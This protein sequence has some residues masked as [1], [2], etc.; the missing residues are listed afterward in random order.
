MNRAAVIIGLQVV[1][2]CPVWR[3]YVERLTTGGGEEAWG[4]LA[5]ATAAGCYWKGAKPVDAEKSRLFPLWLPAA[6]VLVYAAAYPV[7]PPLMRAMV[8]FAAL[9]CTLNLWRFGRAFHPG[10]LGLVC[11]S[12]PLV[13]SLQFYGGYPLRALVAQCAAPLL[14][15][16]GFAVTPE[17]TCLNWGGQ[18]I[19]ID[20]PCSGVRMLWAGLYLACTLACVY[21]LRARRTLALLCI[22]FAAILAGNVWRAV[23]LFYTEAGVVR[24]PAWTHDAAGLMS[25]ALVGIAV[26]LAARYLRR[27]TS[28]GPARTAAK[29]RRFMRRTIPYLIACVLAGAMPFVAVRVASDAVHNGGARAHDFPGWPA[30]FDR[31]ALTELPL[32]ERELRFQ[33]DFPGRTARFTDGRREIVMRWVTEPTRKLHPASACFAGVGYD[34][35][36]LPLRVAADNTRWGCFAATRRDERLRV[37]ERISDA[38]T[39]TAIIGADARSW[40]DVSSWYWAALTNRVAH[41]PWWAVTVAEKEAD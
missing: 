2:F 37:C 11:L 39:I 1:A 23:A 40:P 29:Q 38:A 36:P 20:A 21:E 25:F 27:N 30:Q 14:R 16:G 26:L 22:A 3:W 17:G 24:W 19:W 6:L 35:R 13:P 31:R 28:K 4:L 10:A 7:A 32:T 15:L 12:L 33:D 41:P 34:V 9:G 8:A 18:L 5:L